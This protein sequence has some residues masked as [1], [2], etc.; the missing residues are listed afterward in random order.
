MMIIMMIKLDGIVACLG[1]RG[2]ERYEERDDEL[3]MEDS[4]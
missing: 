3:E 1:E 4:G 2:G